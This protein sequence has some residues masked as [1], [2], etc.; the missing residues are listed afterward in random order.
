MNLVPAKICTC[1]VTYN[2]LQILIF[3]ISILIFEHINFGEFCRFCSRLVKLVRAKSGTLQV[4]LSQFCYEL[5]W[6]ESCILKKFVKRVKVAWK[7]LSCQR[8]RKILLPKGINFSS[9]L[10]ELSSKGQGNLSTLQN[11]VAF[12]APKLLNPFHF[13][14]VFHLG[15]LMFSGDIAMH[16]CWKELKRTLTL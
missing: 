6:A 12:L 14:P 13:T 10:G 15:F 1:A 5:V 2:I 9:N 7:S 4:L 3:S 11:R 8:L 16:H